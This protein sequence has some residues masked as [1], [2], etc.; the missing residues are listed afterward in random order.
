MRLVTG[1]AASS[2]AQSKP[3]R[4]LAG[5]GDFLLKEEDFPPLRPSAKA[6]AAQVATKTPAITPS[7]SHRNPLTP[8]LPSGPQV[9]HWRLSQH[10]IER[11]GQVQSRESQGS[12]EIY[13]E[14]KKII[15]L[16]MI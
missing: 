6:A 16:I 13:S 10:G 5:A 14:N 7:P 4:P 11:V 1:Y 12:S 15:K 2:Q 9:Q 8:P 3:P